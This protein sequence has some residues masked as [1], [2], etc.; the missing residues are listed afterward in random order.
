MGRLTSLTVGWCPLPFDL[1][2]AFL[3]MCS[4]EDLLDFENEEYV[5]SYLGRAQ[6]LAPAIIFTLENLC[7]GHKL[8]LLSLWHVYLLPQDLTT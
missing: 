8:Q 3:H 1:R 7:T 4:W 2:G 5:I 6:L